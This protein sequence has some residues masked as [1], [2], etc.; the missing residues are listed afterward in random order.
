MK[1]YSRAICWFRRDLRLTDHAALYH[2][3]KNSETVYCVFLFDSDILGKLTDRQDRR[4]EFIWRSVAELNESL[5]KRRSALWVLHG[6]AEEQIVSLA[7]K[8]DVQAVF[9]NHDY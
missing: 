2:A 9:C 7:R 6:S 3:L 1:R 5:G 8:F 4:V